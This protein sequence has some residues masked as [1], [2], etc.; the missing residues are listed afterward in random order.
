MDY[1]VERNAKPR[2]REAFVLE[3]MCTDTD[4]LANGPAR[5]RGY[6]SRRVARCGPAQ[7]IVGPQ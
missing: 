5:P 6:T 7:F 2:P 1:K 3:G 4:T